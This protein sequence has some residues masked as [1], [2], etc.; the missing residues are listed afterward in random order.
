MLILALESY[1]LTKG[2]VMNAEDTIRIIEQ[3]ERVLFAKLTGQLSQEVVKE[4][5]EKFGGRKWIAV[6][7]L[8]DLSPPGKEGNELI[9]RMM[10]YALEHNLYHSIEIVPSAVAK[11]SVR[12]AAKNIDVAQWRTTVM[13]RQQAE[14][15]LDEK[16]SQL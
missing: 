4:F 8:T 14:T 7:D 13:D 16:L 9:G 12:E 15:V 11:M 3:R 6:P 5:G 2:V 10:K 1:S